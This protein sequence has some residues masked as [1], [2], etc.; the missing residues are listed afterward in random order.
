MQTY[1]LRRLLIN[2]PVLLGVL[3][4]TF[5]VVRLIPGDAVDARLGEAPLSE[6]QRAEIRAELGLDKSQIRQLAD[7]ISG[8]ASGDLGRSFRTGEAVRGKVADTVLVSLELAFWAIVLSLVIAL[9]L[10]IISAARSNTPV[11][12]LARFVSIIG[13]A[14]PDFV[15]ALLGLIVLTRWFDYLPPVADYRTFTES[16][17]RNLEHLW[18][19]ALI[20]GMRQSAVLARMSRSALLE[21]LRTDYVRTAWSKGLAERTVIGRHALKNAMVPVI[22]IVGTQAGVLVGG[23]VIMEVIFNLP[24]IGRETQEA[25]LNRDYPLIQGNVLV[26]AGI[27]VGMNLVV[28]VSYAWFDPRIR[29]G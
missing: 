18:V 8:I 22:T 27:I 1:I 28:D 24:G 15:L 5:F 29:Q 11:D 20:L 3:V 19:P 26:L 17:V 4:A 2:I 16:P 9:P 23:T 25:V 12:Y 13:L 14:V 10:G 21:V 6:S 7:Y